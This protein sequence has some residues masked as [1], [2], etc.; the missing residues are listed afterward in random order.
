M[1]Y[2]NHYLGKIDN[3]LGTLYGTNKYLMKK[4]TPNCYWFDYL[5]PEIE[6]IA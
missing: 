3:A 6:S 2:L 5:D 4:G 1:S